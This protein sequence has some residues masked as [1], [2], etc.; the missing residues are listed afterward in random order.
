MLSEQ[1]FFSGD[2]DTIRKQAV[3]YALNGLLKIL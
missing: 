3:V 2:R 1:K